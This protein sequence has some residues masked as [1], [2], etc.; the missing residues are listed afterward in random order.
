MGRQFSPFSSLLSS[1]RGILAM[2][3]I[4]S[5]SH[6]CSIYNPIRLLRP[7][8]RCRATAKYVVICVRCRPSR[9]EG[10]E[11]VQYIVFVV[12]T[13]DIQCLFCRLFCFSGCFF[14]SFFFW[15]V[16]FHICTVCVL[17][18][19]Y[20]FRAQL[21]MDGSS[22]FLPFFVCKTKNIYISFF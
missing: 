12:V 15:L 19:I 4:K 21:I 8:C 20:E 13:G 22:I 7:A 2:P 14:V 17:F 11:H 18:W 3:Y 6:Y 9:T 10:E 5:R 16:A 1:D